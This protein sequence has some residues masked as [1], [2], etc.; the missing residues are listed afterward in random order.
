MNTVFMVSFSEMGTQNE[1][2]LT[3]FPHESEGADK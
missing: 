1:P 3:K 2:S